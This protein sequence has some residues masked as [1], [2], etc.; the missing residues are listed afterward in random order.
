MGFLSIENGSLKMKFD[1]SV[2]ELR[3]SGYNVRVCHSRYC[4][5]ELVSYIDT[6]PC[7]FNARGGL[8][9]IQITTPDGTVLNGQAR[10]SREETFSK[11]LGVRIA[12]G[13]ALK[14]VK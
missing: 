11:K 12:I 4:Q 6:E 8:T 7:N 9:T 10:C 5:D 1:F 2:N 13:R 3:K 14:G